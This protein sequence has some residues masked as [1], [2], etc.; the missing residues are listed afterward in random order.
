[1]GQTRLGQR[2]VVVACST[3]LVLVEGVDCVR[4]DPKET[5]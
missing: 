5:I 3:P 1:M 4:T 2:M